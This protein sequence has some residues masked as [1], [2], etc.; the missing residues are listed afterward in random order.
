M[1]A[2]N[3]FTHVNRFKEELIPRH[4]GVWQSCNLH[5]LQ[6]F[7]LLLAFDPQNYPEY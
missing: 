6:F 2:P 5:S 3:L 1:V 4:C 7:G